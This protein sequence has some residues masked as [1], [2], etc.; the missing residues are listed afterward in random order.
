MIAAI[1]ARKSTDDS[2]KNEEAR[3]T[4]RQIDRATAYATAKG[5]TVDPRAIF[6]DEAV[7][8]AGGKNPP[9]VHPAPAPRGPWPAVRGARGVGAVADRARP[10]HLREDPRH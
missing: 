8:G 9:G 4:A 7:S 1:Y 5:W 10:A 2:D 3:S 6:V